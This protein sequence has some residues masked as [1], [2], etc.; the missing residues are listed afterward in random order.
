MPGQ[1]EL[2]CAGISTGLHPAGG[3]SYTIRRVSFS[4][5]RDICNRADGGLIAIGGCSGEI[6]TATRRGL[7]PEWKGGSRDLGTCGGEWLS[8]FRRAIGR[9]FLCKSLARRLPTTDVE[10]PKH[11]AVCLPKRNALN[12]FSA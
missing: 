6:W 7:A 12:T 8:A 2:I 9:L 10:P 1:D 4:P 5:G 11:L 3:D